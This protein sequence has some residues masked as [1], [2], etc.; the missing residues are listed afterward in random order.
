MTN[1]H[2]KDNSKINSYEDRRASVRVKKH[3][4]LDFRYGDKNDLIRA[5]IMNFSEGGVRFVSP[6]MVELGKKLEM[7]I[8]NKVICGII[9]ECK[10]L[11]NG[12]SVRIEFI[13]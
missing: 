13:Q 5:Q 9:L 2:Q 4:H 10:N 7:T 1:N 12:Y 6:V 3:G 11:Y 8:D